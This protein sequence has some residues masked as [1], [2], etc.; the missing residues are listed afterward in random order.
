MSSQGLSLAPRISF[1]F[2]FRYTT[3]VIGKY[4]NSIGTNIDLNFRHTESNNICTA[5]KSNSA[6]PHIR[7]QLS[8][9]RHYMTLQLVC[10]DL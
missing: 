2:M 8:S 3:Y 5:G 7:I 6:N 4:I 10:V 1:L 9:Y